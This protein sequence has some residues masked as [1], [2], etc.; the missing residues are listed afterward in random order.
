M[1]WIPHHS[2][3]QGPVTRQ[4]DTR[5]ARLH[6]GAFDSCTTLHA[7]RLQ[8]HYTGQNASADKRAYQRVAHRWQR[9]AAITRNAYQ[10]G[11]AATNKR[12]PT[13]SCSYSNTC[14]MQRGNRQC[15]LRFPS[16]EVLLLDLWLQP[17]AHTHTAT[18][19]M[20]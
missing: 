15:A 17:T 4:H 1:S 6:P 2:V 12:A 11:I 10:L 19:K 20:L 7:Y 14:W 9:A 16:H 13:L 5:P 3:H 8:I 18:V